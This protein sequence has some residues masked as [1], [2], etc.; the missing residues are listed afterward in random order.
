MEN[1]QSACVSSY[2]IM[3]NEAKYQHPNEFDGLRFLKD[4]SVVPGGHSMSGE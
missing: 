3:H 2:D 1:G 4:P